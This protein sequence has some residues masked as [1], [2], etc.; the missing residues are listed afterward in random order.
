MN[1]LGETCTMRRKRATYQL[2]V[3]WFSTKLRIK[4]NFQKNLKIAKT[5]R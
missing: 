4:I 3:A 5:D 1:V 2:N